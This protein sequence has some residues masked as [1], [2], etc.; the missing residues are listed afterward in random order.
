MIPPDLLQWSN[1]MKAFTAL[2]SGGALGH[3]E[4]VVH[5]PLLVYPESP[6][7]IILEVQAEVFGVRRMAAVPGKTFQTAFSVDP[8]GQ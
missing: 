2:W 3:S 8:S 6:T 4:V 1:M 5:V 7:C